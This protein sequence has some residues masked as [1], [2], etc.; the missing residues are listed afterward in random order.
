MK[1]KTPEN[2]KKKYENIADMLLPN[3][4]PADVTKLSSKSQ[5]S[6]SSDSR[7]ESEYKPPEI[8]AN[9]RV[10]IS[11]TRT[12]FL[13]LYDILV[14]V[15]MDSNSLLQWGQSNILEPPSSNSTSSSQ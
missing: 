14:R 4:S 10:I 6:H 15:S 8:I 9:N 3:A 12:T 5:S 13:G 11:R 2:I 1:R 7:I